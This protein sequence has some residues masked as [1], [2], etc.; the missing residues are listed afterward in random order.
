MQPLW[1]LSGQFFGWYNNGNLLFNRIGRNIGYLEN[2]IFFNHAGQYIGSLFNQ[3]RIA[4]QNGI[5]TPIGTPL[6]PVNPENVDNPLNPIEP[7]TEYGWED[8]NFEDY[9]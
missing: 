1:Q 5:I 7:I 9:L 2:G 4:I 6:N 8:I 3:E